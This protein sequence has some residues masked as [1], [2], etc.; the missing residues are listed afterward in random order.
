MMLRFSELVD[1]LLTSD[2]MAK[3]RGSIAGGQWYKAGGQW[4]KA[5]GQWYKAGGQ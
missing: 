1:F 3:G 2:L 5:G 4:Y